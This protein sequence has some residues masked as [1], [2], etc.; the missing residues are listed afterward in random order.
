[1]HSATLCRVKGSAFLNDEIQVYR[2][3]QLI[4][5]AYLKKNKHMGEK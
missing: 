4:T 1:M 2:S 3:V 5:N